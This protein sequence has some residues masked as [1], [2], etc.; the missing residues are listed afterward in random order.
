MLLIA[1]ELCWNVYPPHVG[2]SSLLFGCHVT[3]VLL[4]MY[5]GHYPATP[6]KPEAIVVHKK[7]YKKIQ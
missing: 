7:P 4:C 5:L 3:L 6:Y 2:M 1:I